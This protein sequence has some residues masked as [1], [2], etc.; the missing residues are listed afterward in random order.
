MEYEKIVEYEKIDKSTD[1]SVVLHAEIQ[2]VIAGFIAREDQN[3]EIDL[4]VAIDS[5]VNMLL[6]SHYLFILKS[7]GKDEALKHLTTDF[8]RNMEFLLEQANVEVKS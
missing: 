8:T 5:G 6:M 1:I 4:F 3:E 2:K 7:E